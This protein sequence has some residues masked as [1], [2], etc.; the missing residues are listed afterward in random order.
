[1]TIRLR[2]GAA[3]VAA[4]LVAAC[5]QGQSQSSSSAAPSASATGASDGLDVNPPGGII[6]GPGWYAVEHYGGETF[7]WAKNDAQITA[8]PDA[9]DR[10]LAMMLEAGPAIG[11]KTAR[12]TIFGNHGDRTLAS[13]TGRQFVKVN[14]ASGVRGETF[15]IHADSKN[16]PAPHGDPRTLNYRLLEATLGFSTANCPNEIARDGTLGVG[17]G[18]YPF[19]TFNGATF[20][21]VNNDA[22]IVVNNAQ[23]KPFTIQMEVAPGPSLGGAPLALTLAGHGAAATSGTPVRTRQIV[24]IT[25]PPQ[26]AGAKLTLATHSKDVPA[27]HDKRTLN[28]QVFD[29]WVKP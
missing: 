12:L 17:S 28:F 11:S 15:T 10:T 7:R 26:P 4:F 1:M 27:P 2:L 29:L 14:I 25:V 19:E 16:L 21:W 20:R 18:W 9:S 5:S 6:F 3:L 8:C 24:S 22:Q 13:L 23:P